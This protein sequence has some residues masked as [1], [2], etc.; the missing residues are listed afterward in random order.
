MAGRG[1]ADG[2]ATQHG[3]S[4]LDL[5]GGWPFPLPV[6]VMTAQPVDGLGCVLQV[7]VECAGATHGALR[8]RFPAVQARFVARSAVHRVA[9]SVGPW[10][11]QR[12]P[13]V[14]RLGWRPRRRTVG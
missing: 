6:A 5:L 12:P 3:A 1:C 13:R 2:S 11:G 8:R 4:A 14:V 7:R 10:T 9:V